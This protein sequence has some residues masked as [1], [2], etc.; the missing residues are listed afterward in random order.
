MPRP[1]ET[2][3]SH[4]APPTAAATGAAASTAGV[5]AVA[6]D[7][8][9]GGPGGRGAPPPLALVLAGI[10]SVQFGASVAKNLFP[11]LGAGG[12][13][14][15]RLSVSALLLLVVARRSLRLLSRR[16]VGPV[17]MLGAVLATM[18]FTF[19][20]S[21]ERIPLGVA[22]TV[23]FL[24]PLAVAVGGARRA[25]DL[26]WALLALAGVLVLT[27]G[28]SALAS[29]AIDPTGAGLAIAAGVCWAAYI[30]L[31]QR[32]GASLPGVSGLALSLLVGTVVVAPIGIAQAGTN[33][34]HPGLLAAGAAVAVLS[35]AIP[36]AC[37]MVALRQLA[38]RTFGVLM[39]LEPA[40]AALVG[41]L[42]L[43]E[44]IGWTG[45]AGIT[46]VCVASAGATRA[47]PTGPD[48]AVD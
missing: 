46:L 47:A 16:S 3:R 44:G 8:S 43:G 32:V 31:T 25:R 2:D 39:S 19:Y 18:N 7:R 45:W 15:L 35:S 41:L 13:V 21:L 12:T 38:A 10:L 27:D 30:G 23:E 5:P 34:L 40:V 37:E 17:L 22:V 20:E 26:L 4:P 6:P 9:A 24:G 28:G 33:L 1:A 48:L 14:L 11:S 42:V 36:Y 29:G